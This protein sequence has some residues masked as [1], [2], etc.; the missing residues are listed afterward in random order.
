MEISLDDDRGGCDIKDG[1]SAMPISSGADEIGEHSRSRSHS[2]RRSIH[3]PGAPPR[4]PMIGDG[5]PLW[6]G[7]SESEDF[8]LG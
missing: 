2:P 7:H 4:S 5:T 1:E 8:S 6:P 3:N